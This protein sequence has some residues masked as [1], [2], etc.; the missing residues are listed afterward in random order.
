MFGL[1]ELCSVRPDFAQSGV[2]GIKIATQL[3]ELGY[4][5]GDVFYSNARLCS[6]EID[7]I[8]TQRASE[9]KSNTRDTRFNPEVRI[10]KESYVLIEGFTKN[11]VS[12]NLFFSQ[13]VI[14]T[15]LSCSLSQSWV[16]H[17]FLFLPHQAVAQGQPLT[18]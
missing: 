7:N 4:K 8:A 15:I 17:T 3:F 16:I 2:S 1:A 10:H 18:V 9:S 11:C 12:L 6:A 14:K 13:E 5:L